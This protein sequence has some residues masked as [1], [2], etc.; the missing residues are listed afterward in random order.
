V[1]YRKIE[2]NHVILP[3]RLEALKAFLNSDY[4]GMKHKLK[5]A[6][7]SNSEDALTWTCFDVLRNLDNK[8][9]IVAI[10]EIIEDAYSAKLN[11]SANSFQNMEIDIGKKFEGPKFNESTEL[12]ASIETDV[13]IIFFEAKLY[14]AMSLAKPDK[15]QDQIE[16]KLRTGIDY[17]S[18]LNKSF[19]FIMLD[20]AP[21]EKMILRKSKE[22]ALK[23]YSNYKDKWKTAWW[24]N[25]YKNGRNNSM[26]PLNN[27]LSD[28]CLGQQNYS[29]STI[30]R[31]MGW[32]TW[33][34]LFKTILRGLVSQYAAD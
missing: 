12:D 13:L 3:G 8:N 2:R 15:L 31:N 19:Y 11:L 29:V 30:S 21:I 4:K 23:G 17:A 24:F 16:R 10:K 1:R 14:S 9:K 22:E 32:L 5:N 18:S 20:I 7:N 6:T 34:C 33:P 25:Y 27:I 28:L 26:K